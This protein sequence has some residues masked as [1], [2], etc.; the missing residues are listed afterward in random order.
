MWGGGGE[1]G[2]VCVFVCLGGCAVVHPESSYLRASLLVSVYFSQ[3]FWC[4]LFSFNKG[5]GKRT[6]VCV[7][8][9]RGGGG[10]GMCAFGCV[11]V[12]VCACVC[13]CVCVCVY[14]CTCVYVCVCGILM[15]V[16][17]GAYICM[18]FI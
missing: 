14:V 11:C 7:C 6:T 2:G 4:Y 3:Y 9:G 17:G 16:R 1:G 12:C 13:V 5:G 15:G 18:G 10:G 8:V